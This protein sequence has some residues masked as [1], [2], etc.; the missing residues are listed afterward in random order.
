MFVDSTIVVTPCVPEVKEE[1]KQAN[2]SHG[3]TGRSE[4]Q[5]IGGIS[6]SRLSL[7]PLTS[8]LLMRG[9]C[10][11]HEQRNKYCNERERERDEGHGSE[12]SARQEQRL[13]TG[14]G[15]EGEEEEAREQRS[16]KKRGTDALLPPS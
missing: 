13:T 12:R 7:T 11:T 16:S 4:R 3:N 14:K 6:F 2:E 10:S 1:R 15:T 9:E 8:S 5:S